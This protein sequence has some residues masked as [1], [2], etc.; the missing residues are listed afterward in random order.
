MTRLTRD[1]LTARI[2]YI[3]SREMYKSDNSLLFKWMFNIR[4]VIVI[5][6]RSYRG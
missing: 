5:I 6:V 2:V 4:D 1:L 3:R